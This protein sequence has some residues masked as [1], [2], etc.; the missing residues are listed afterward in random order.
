MNDTPGPSSL[1]LH[2]KIVLCCSILRQLSVVKILGLSLNSVFVLSGQRV[3]LKGKKETRK[4]ELRTMEADYVT[5]PNNSISNNY[6]AAT[7]RNFTDRRVINVIIYV[8]LYKCQRL[9]YLRRSSR[10]PR[11]NFFSFLP[12]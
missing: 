7:V 3:T 2:V 12:Q 9:V 5:L 4:I 11:C 8:R 10:A 6:T 1:V